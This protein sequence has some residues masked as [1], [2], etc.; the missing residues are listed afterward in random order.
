M[1]LI[2]FHVNFDELSRNHSEELAKQM[3]VYHTLKKRDACL[4]EKTSE[5]FIFDFSFVRG[6][7]IYLV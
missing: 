2:R 3:K 5:Y 1:A 7:Y 6:C 4:T